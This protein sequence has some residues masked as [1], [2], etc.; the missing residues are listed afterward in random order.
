MPLIPALGRQRQAVFRIPGEPALQSKF[1]Y[2]QGYAEKP[3]QKRKRKKERKSQEVSTVIKWLPQQTNAHTYT[4]R[5]GGQGT[6]FTLFWSK[7]MGKCTQ[8]KVIYLV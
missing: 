4:E 2:N 1:W 8:L 5:G 7:G 6:I 3:C